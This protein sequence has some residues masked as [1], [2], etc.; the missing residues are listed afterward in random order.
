MTSEEGDFY[1][2]ANVVDGNACGAYVFSE[3]DQIIEI[4]FNYLDVPC[5]NG[6]L[7]AVRNFI[8]SLFIG[9]A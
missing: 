5:E 4:R 8:F 2:K 3:P 1:H 9:E 6:G 7:V